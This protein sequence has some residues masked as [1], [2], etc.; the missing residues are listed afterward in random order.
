MGSYCGCEAEA[1]IAALMGEHALVS[2][3]VYRARQ[4]STKGGWKTPPRRRNRSPHCSTAIPWTKR[5][6][7]SLS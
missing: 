1:V 4:H 5:P 3:L 7:S 2:G 6:G